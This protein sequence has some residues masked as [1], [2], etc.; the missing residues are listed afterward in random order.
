[1]KFRF[2]TYIAFVLLMVA[3]QALTASE[4]PARAVPF[5][6]DSVWFYRDGTRVV[7]EIS[8]Q[9]L[10]V[11]FD[12]RYSSTVD[13]VTSITGSNDGFI[14]K[15]ARAIIK[16]HSQLSDYFHD[17]NLA[18]DACF[19]KLR[20]GVK[21]GD[22]RILISRLQQDNTIRYVHPALVINNRTY[23][24]FNQFELEWKTGIDP[25]RRTALLRAAY[26]TV[27]ENDEKEKRY[28]V[29]V[30]SIPFFR[31]IN[32]L[33]EDVRTLR[34]TPHLV[35]IKPTISA[36][37]SLFMN[38]GTI[39]DSVPFSLTISFTDRVNIDPSSLSTLDLR[40]AELQKELFDCVFDPYDYTRAVTK[41][42]VV[43]T[44]RIR[45][46]A[47]GEYTIP[48]VKI[49]YSCPTCSDR[50]V[51]SIESEPAL[52]MVASI[53]PDARPEYRLI[54]PADPVA[55][56]FQQGV[57]GGQARLYLWCAI[58]CGLGLSACAVWVFFLIRAHGADPEQLE[59]RKK[60]AQ[61]VELL[62]AQLHATPNVP[63]WRYLADVGVLLREYLVLHYGVEVKYQGGG[64][65]RFMETLAGRIP[66]EF[67]APLRDIFDAIDTCVALEA[68]LCPDLE[69]LRSAI[70]NIVEPNAH[71]GA[72]RG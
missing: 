67:F 18:V 53:I 15:K 52:F 27:D 23:A 39:G 72:G 2:A 54:V 6:F 61:L 12:P 68:E 55:P 49:G 63:Q 58:I 22:I 64:G 69:Q 16:S 45:F 7:P 24:F 36:K 50:G 25:S 51:R 40:P 3:F 34:V 11:V 71:N 33:A 59:Q 57:A 46:Y 60:E 35:E 41:S 30:A 5:S 37:L 13:E 26:A 44:G 38:G 8:T 10:T 28:L 65:H 66:V 62:G 47:P 14:R 32:L 4:A 19:F 56:V 1:M 48:P 70:Q 29:D 9:W 31:A 17:P 42:P 20:P 43:I 21:S